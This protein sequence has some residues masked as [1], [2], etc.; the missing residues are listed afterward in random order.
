MGIGSNATTPPPGFPKNYAQNWVFVAFVSMTP[1]QSCGILW[2]QMR[3]HFEAEGLAYQMQYLVWVPGLLFGNDWRGNLRPKIAPGCVHL[4]RS[5][6]SHV[7]RY[8]NPPSLILSRRNISTHP[9]NLIFNYLYKF[10]TIQNLSLNK[11]EFS[12]LFQHARVQSCGTLWVLIR[13]H[14]KAETNTYLLVPLNCG[15]SS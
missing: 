15:F 9:W 6:F 3:Y 8:S 1:V 14:W 4:A 7:E 10:F 13:Y 2:Q 11:S 12:D 5:L